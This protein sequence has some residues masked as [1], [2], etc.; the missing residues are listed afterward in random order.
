MALA[1]TSPVISSANAAN[2]ALPTSFVTGLEPAW[3][4]A[5]CVGRVHTVA[6]HGGD[7]F[8]LYEALATC[9]PGNVLVADLGGH[10]GCGHWGELMSRAALALGVAGLVINGAIR[11]RLE[12]ATLEFPV[13]HR[14]VS[15]RTATKQTSGTLA[16]TLRQD[17]FEHVAEGDLIIA[18]A[19]GAAVI[20]AWVSEDEVQRALE[21]VVS[22]ES[23]IMK[24]ISE[25]ASVTHAFGVLLGPTDH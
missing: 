2:S 14:G 11:D 6:G 18:D 19:D 22:K 24:R 9:R 12:I 20:P 23:L 21:Q 17:P 10:Q 8:A 15:P 5:R 13:F 25:G 4:A 16:V 3:P 1:A 7:N